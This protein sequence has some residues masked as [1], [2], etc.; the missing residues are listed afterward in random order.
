VGKLIYKIKS[1]FCNHINLGEKHY[2]YTGVKYNSHF[3]TVQ[4]IEHSYRYC[5]DC[6][7]RIESN[8]AGWTT[9]DIV[10]ERVVEKYERNNKGK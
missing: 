5:L 4:A 3:G 7:K 2:Y 10:K 1:I 9:L 6:G 8:L